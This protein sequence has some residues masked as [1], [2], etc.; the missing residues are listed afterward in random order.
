MVIRGLVIKVGHWLVP[1]KWH[2]IK[3]LLGIF[4]GRGKPS[5]I[6]IWV[7]WLSWCMDA[8]EIFCLRASRHPCDV[9]SWGS[10]ALW[11]RS[12]DLAFYLL[13]LVSVVLWIIN[14]RWMQISITLIRSTL[15]LVASKWLI[16]R[17]L[18]WF[19]LVSNLAACS[20]SFNMLT[21][22]VQFAFDDLEIVSPY[23]LTPI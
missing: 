21:I 19:F 14:L 22:G 11:P 20:F 1:S 4:K 5:I 7:R 9:S 23:I 3:E 2:V 13:L 17:S 6:A 15:S 8:L 18:S 12:T 16:D 10:R